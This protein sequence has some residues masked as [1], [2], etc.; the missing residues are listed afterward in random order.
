MADSGTAAA[1]SREDRKKN[2]TSIKAVT[3]HTDKTNRIAN[4]ACRGGPFPRIRRRFLPG[5]G[6]PGPS[7]PA[8]EHSSDGRHVFSRGGFMGKTQSP[9]RA[10]TQGA[11]SFKP[12]IGG[13]VG[14]S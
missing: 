6:S 7:V 1:T 12:P 11:L 4:P 5:Y 14:F 8:I 10:S 2:A 13:I 9:L 3:A